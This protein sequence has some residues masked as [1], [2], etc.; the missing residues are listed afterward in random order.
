MEN[1]TNEEKDYYELLA[2]MLD[3]GIIDDSERNILNKRKDKYGI[4]DGR[5]KEI[6]DF[7]IKEYSESKTPQFET[8]GERDYYELLVDMLEDGY[9][10][11]SGRNILNKRKEK[12]KI[13]DDRAEE[14]E[15]LAKKEYLVN[16][17][18]QFETEGEYKYYELGKT[19]YFNREYDKAIEIFEAIELNSN[20]KIRQWL[21]ISYSYYY[22]EFGKALYFNGEYDKA[23]ESLLEYVK[24]HYNY[25]YDNFYWLGCSYYFNE[26]YKEAIEYL[27]V[28]A[29]SQ[30]EVSSTVIAKSDYNWR[31]LCRVWY[32][33][34]CANFYLELYDN[35]IDCYKKAI[36]INEN[37]NNYY[38]TH[39][40]FNMYK[41]NDIAAYWNDYGVSLERVNR[42]EDAKNCY[43]IASVLDPNEKLYSNNFNKVKVGKIIKGIGNLFK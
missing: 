36:D 34:G 23:I 41:N 21:D 24:L 12:Y 13:S 39:L 35:A 38:F 31:R 43:K 15:S 22:Y 42:L 29:K 4:S 16:E 6:K 26:Q 1:L 9:I 17:K 7:A 11:D 40:I 25:D 18:P 5:A 37:W 28:V 19:L 3:D 2:G 20:N 27:L 33:L 8:D 32:L 30:I 14:L 10:S